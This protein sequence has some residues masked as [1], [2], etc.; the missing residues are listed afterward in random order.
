MKIVKSLYLSEKSSDFDEI[1]Y[2]TAYIEP[3][4]SHVTKIKFLKFKMADGRHVE[5][6]FSHSSSNNCPILAK[7]CKMTQNGMPTKAT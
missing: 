5:N 7:F 4:D 3:D 6:R 2:T 1:W